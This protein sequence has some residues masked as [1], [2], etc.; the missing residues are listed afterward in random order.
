[1]KK[2]LAIISTHPIQYNAPVFK[3]LAQR[4]KIDIKVFYTWGTKVLEKKYDPG[5][6]KQIEWDIP[7]LEGYSYTFV[8]N[9]SSDPGS[10]HFMG[11][12][13]P[14]LNKEIEEWGADAVLVFGWSFKAHLNALRYFKNKTKILFR[15]DST[16]IDEPVGFTFKKIFRKFFLK[17]VYRNIDFALY[18]GSANKQYYLKHGVKSAQLVFTPHAIDNNRFA[19]NT[20]TTKRQELNISSNAIVFLFAGKFETKKNPL[21]LFDTFVQLNN[22]NSHL[23]LVGNGK[24][25]NELKKKLA[26]LSSLIKNNIHILSFQN[27]SEMP[28]IYKMADVFCLP[29]K[30]PGETWGLA[31]NEAMA[32]GCAIIASDKCGCAEDLVKNEANGYIVKSDDGNDLAKKMNYFVETQ[33]LELM[34]K[35]SLNI[36]KDWSFDKICDAIEQTV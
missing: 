35:A 31:I 23:V 26:A 30:G 13:N 14:T 24:L 9:T 22:T 27:Q 33:Q 7:L 19:N 32:C 4:G 17:W 11:I 20:I 8:N 12:V 2:K 36:I 15:G 3:L 28:A 29:S 10:H 6:G 25:E 5:F 16:L 34:K 1:M 21:L 18:V